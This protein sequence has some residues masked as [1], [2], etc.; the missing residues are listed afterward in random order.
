MTAKKQNRVNFKVN[1]EKRGLI[2]NTFYRVSLD[3]ALEIIVENVPDWTCVVLSVASE[4]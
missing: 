3:E 1:S 4:R 2:E